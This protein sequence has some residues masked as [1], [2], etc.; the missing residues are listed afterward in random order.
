MDKQRTIGKDINIKGVGLHTGNKVN[1]RLLP[2]DTDAGINFIRIDLAGHPVIKAVMENAISHGHSPRRTS[3][4]IG[5][6]QIHTIEHL[7]AALLGL[8]IDNINIEMDNNEVAGLDGSSLGF[9]DALISAGIKEQDKHKNYCII[10]EPLVVEENGCSLIALPSQDFKVSYTLQYEHSFLGTQ[11]MELAVSAESFNNEIASAR[12]FCLEE[13][14]QELQS[15]GV[16]LG[17]NYDNTLVV[18]KHGVVKN[19]LRYVNEFVRHKILDLLGD[20][21]LLGMPV[22]GHIV[23]IRSGH[24][25]NLKLVK[26]ILREKEKLFLGGISINHRPL[27]GESLEAQDIMK[28]LPHR[29]PFLFVDRV[30]SLERGK[31]AVGIKNV[32][33]N[34]YFFKGHFPGRPVMPGVLM[35]EAMAQVGG[36]MMLSSAENQGKLAFFLAINNVK[37]R[38]TVVPGDQLVLDVVA[39]KLKSKTGQVHGKAFVDGKVV[40]EADLMFAIIESK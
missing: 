8:G 29:D 6:V 17:A 23:A 22:K 13:E 30:V 28:I 39:G 36:V 3:I 16:G 35:I 15:H 40:A 19:K 25:M 5:E 14:V 9:V 31:H 11:F 10:R 21:S 27:E 1:M 37:F 26:K 34:D 33:V 12:T 38:K 18:G 7:M 4:G 2:A 24:S 20:I 32:T